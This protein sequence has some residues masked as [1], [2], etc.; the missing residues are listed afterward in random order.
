MFVATTL[1]IMTVAQAPAAP[2]TLS[3]QVLDAQGQPAPGIEVLLSALEQG[4]TAH[5][6]LARTKCDQAGRFQIDVPAQKD[7]SKARFYLAFGPMS[8]RRPG[9]P[10]V[11]NV[12]D[13]GI[14]IGAPETRQ[15]CQDGRSRGRSRWQAGGR[16]PCRPAIVRVAGGLP[17]SSTFP[18]P[19]A[20]AEMLAA[21]TDADGNG[22]ISGCGA[23]DIEA[24]LVAAAAFGLQGSELIADKAGGC[25]IALKPAGRV[26]G[27]V[28]ADDPS[29][30]R[31]LEV[32]AMMRPPAST[33]PQMNGNARTTTNAEGRFEIPA[34]A[35]GELALNVF[36]PDGS[37]LRPKL[38][39][40]LKV[41]PGKTI[42]VTIRLEGPPRER[43]VA[44]RI[45]DRKGQ[46]IAGAV[47]FQTG[48]SQT[49]TEAQTSP[50]GR[51]ELSGVVTR[52]TFLF[53]R[54]SGYR[55][56][57]RAIA[58]DA[59]TVTLMMHK[60]DEPPR[61]VR[62]TLAP[63]LPRQEELA[64]V[65]RLID[66]YAER[67]FKGGGEAEKVRTLEALARL[68]PERVLEIVQQ[69]KVFNAPFYNG[70]VGLQLAIGM[71]DESM[72]E[73]LAV[74]ESLEDPA[75][76]AIGYMH[77]STK[78]ASQN[79]ACCARSAR[80]RALECTG[81]QGARRH[82]ALA[83]RAGRRGVSRPRSSRPRPGNPARRGNAGEDSSQGRLGRLRRARSP[84]N[85][86]RSIP[87]P[88]WHL[89]RISLTLAN[90]TAI[91]AT[92]LMSWRIEIQPGPSQCWRW[93]GIVSSA[94]S[95]PWRVVHR[96][97]AVDLDRA[98]RLAQSI[99]DESIK[100]FAL[101]MMAL[102][103]SLSGK[104]AAQE[105]LEN[106]YESLERCPAPARRNRPRCTSSPRSR[107]FCCRWW[108]ESTLSSST[109]ISGAPGDAPAQDVGSRV[110]RSLARSRRRAAGDD[111]GAVRPGH[112][113]LADRAAHQG[114]GER[115][116]LFRGP[117]RAV[118]R[119]RRDR[120]EVGR[121]SCRG[122][123]RE[124][125]PED[126]ASPELR[127]ACGRRRAG[128]LGRP[129]VPEASAF[130]LAALGAGC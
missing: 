77:A 12:S 7:P 3:G 57:G 114:I 53:A 128:P 62:K 58:A 98:R 72:D 19:D 15:A 122:P 107:A 117:R 6:V 68:E 37:K 74:L 67:V 109:S 99:S 17:P 55:F 45:V 96:M 28:L 22:Q 78:L 33:R 35:A 20:L 110:E 1:L 16:R 41:E 106:A 123:A 113:A 82:P 124:C 70:M 9:W 51:F 108:N 10:G 50:D 65:R 40:G 71:M 130:F 34:I 36:V 86:C 47:V 121:R 31:G 102:G 81:S 43:T 76:K 75:A 52:P 13:A 29:A 18:P 4:T 39:D 94:S 48:D 30:A 90:S 61:E 127:P 24:V 97:A 66:P 115:R 69:K 91:T 5:P 54:K 103:L 92:L 84:K 101:G 25:V 59:E 93:S 120:P 14:R 11:C 112:C 42:E 56:A 73:V 83:H 46:P 95:T 21:R 79:R 119:S 129:A 63:L 27:R 38:P 26:T 118:R 87:M 49:R 89:P 80:A 125:R 85:W 105:V 23:Q 126:P 88:R 116:G 60:Q 111:A 64:L 2:T 100:G 44:G 8:Q 104:P 32:I